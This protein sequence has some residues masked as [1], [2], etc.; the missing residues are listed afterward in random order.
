[1]TMAKYIVTNNAHR[2]EAVITVKSDYGD[3][4]YGSPEIQLQYEIYSG[5]DKQRYARRKLSEI[6]RKLCGASSCGC[7]NKWSEAL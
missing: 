3:R 1:M 6:K 2:S 5:G 7:V 4:N